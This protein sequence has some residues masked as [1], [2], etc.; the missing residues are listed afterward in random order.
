M[1]R[2][3]KSAPASHRAKSISKN[4]AI[5]KFFFLQ[6]QQEEHLAAFLKASSTIAQGQRT[7]ER[8]GGGAH[9][10]QQ[11]KLTKQQRRLQD[12]ISVLSLSPDLKTQQDG[13]EEWP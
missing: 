4:R 9:R 10:E 3:A 1:Y 12:K 11:S 7:S 13:R 8:R 6:Q 5:C 2:R